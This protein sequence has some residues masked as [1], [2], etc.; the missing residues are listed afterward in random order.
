MKH[1]LPE[2]GEACSTIHGPFEQFELVDLTL[3][4]AV[5]IENGEPGESCFLVS[6]QSFCKTLHFGE[7]AL[8]YLL[9]PVFEAMAFT[10]AYDLPK[11]LNEHM[12]SRKLC[13]RLAQF[14]KICTLI[15]FEII[16]GASN[17]EDALLEPRH[18]RAQEAR[19]AQ[20]S[21]A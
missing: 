15:C 14:R 3:Y 5:G 4:L 2:Q 20:L 11:R 13:A 21:P 10:F 9:F 8:G 7:A 18:A 16:K 17:E 1:T 6:F 12:Q 19:E